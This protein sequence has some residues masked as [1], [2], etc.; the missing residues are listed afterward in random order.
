[1]KVFSVA[2]WRPIAARRRFRHLESHLRCAFRGNWVALS[3]TPVAPEAGVTRRRI[4]EPGRVWAVSRRTTRRHYLFNPDEHGQMKRIYWYALAHAALK[5]GVMVHGA[6]LMSTHGHE[7][8]T[9]VQ[10]ELPLFLHTFHRLLALST[11]AYRGWPEEVFNKQSTSMVALLTPEAIVDALGYLIAN[12]VS[13]NAVRY[14]KD[15]PGALTMPRHIGQRTVRIKRPDHYYDP[16]RWPQFLELPIVMPAV[17]Q[18]EYGN[19]EARVEV[20]RVLKRKERA[21]LG[22]SRRTGVPFLGT[23]RVTRLQHTKRASS[24]E[25]FGSL[26]PRLK[27]RGDRDAAKRYVLQVKDFEHRYE[28]QL[29]RWKKGNRHVEFPFGTWWMRVH[30]GVQCAQAP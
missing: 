20:A 1:M 6:C 22:E 26:N 3:G 30:H 16:E 21:A 23:K 19:S 15:W 2:D 9:D 18:A 4:I 14:A 12:P 5:H 25:P 7:I 29:R 28:T 27:A 24:H 13:A 11:K 17:L 8:V 10:G